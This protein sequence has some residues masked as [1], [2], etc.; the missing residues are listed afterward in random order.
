MEALILN[1]IVIMLLVVFICLFLF[2]IC[3]ELYTYFK[4]KYGS[5]RNVFYGGVTESIGTVVVG[6]V[7]FEIM[8]VEAS[9]GARH[10]GLEIC[11]S[12]SNSSRKIELSLYSKEA[13]ELA[14]LL[15]KAAHAPPPSSKWLQDR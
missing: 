13:L 12:D 3:R 5:L 6:A 9:K 4:D 1:I 2:V 8:S 7:K 14:M 15:Q 10:V 11:Y